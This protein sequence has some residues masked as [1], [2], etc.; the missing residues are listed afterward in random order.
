M[1]CPAINKLSLS[2]NDRSVKIGGVVQSIK[3]IYL[4]NKKSMAF[5]TLENTS[6]SIECLVFPKMYKKTLEIWT[7]GSLLMIDGK[8]ST[9]DGECKLI[10]DSVSP[11]GREALEMLDRIKVTKRK[12]GQEVQNEFKKSPEK[13]VTQTSSKEE[14]ILSIEDTSLLIRIP[15]HT[16]KEKLEKL[17]LFLRNLPE[18]TYSVALSLGEKTI[19]TSFRI[20][21]TQEVGISLRKIFS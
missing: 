9:K 12:Y 16:P 18:G 13:I 21:Y 4:K 20:E 5:V 3:Q 8:I 1:V 17:S 7:E 6:G 14:N 11:L 19:Q 10:V 2:D 15:E